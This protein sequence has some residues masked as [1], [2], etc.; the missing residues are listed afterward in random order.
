MEH[1]A[2]AGEEDNASSRRAE[3][4]RGNGEGNDRGEERRTGGRDLLALASLAA[5]DPGEHSSCLAQI[6]RIGGFSAVARSDACLHNALNLHHCR[7]L[8]RKEKEAN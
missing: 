2:G 5:G 3:V 8:G 4:L 7:G 6:M 1:L